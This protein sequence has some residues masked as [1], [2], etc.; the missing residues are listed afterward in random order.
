MNKVISIVII[1]SV[2]CQIAFSQ[3][4]EFKLLPRIGFENDNFGQSVS[5]DG[6]YAIVGAPGAEKVFVF[7]KSGSNWTEQEI[8]TGDS[9][10]SGSTLPSAFGF[11]VSISGTYA[12]VGAP[13]QVVLPILNNIGAAYI[14][15]R[16][17]ENWVLQNKI[18]PPVGRSFG[19][20]GWSV[21]I[22]TT[23]AVVGEANKNSAYIYKRDGENW[24]LQSTFSNDWRF[25]ESV[26]ISGDYISIGTVGGSIF[27]EGQGSAYIFFNDGVKWTQ[28]ANFQASEGSNVDGFGED[29]FISSTNLIAGDVKAENRDSISTGAA[30]IFNRE[31]TLWVEKQKITAGD[32]SLGDLFGAS[33]SL[34]G[35]YAIISAPEDQDKGIKSG[36]AYL[37]RNDG[38][39]W[40]EDQKLLASDGGAND[41]FGFAVSISGNNIIVGANGNDDNGNNSGSAYI[42]SDLVTYIDDVQIS[43]LHSFNLSQNYP[44]PF[45]PTTTIQYS[46]SVAANVKL[47]IY[48]LLGQKVATLVN[49]DHQ[50]GAYSVQ[51]DGKDESGSIV[52]SGIYT[53]RLEARERT[54]TRKL[55]LIR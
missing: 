44:N 55:V 25:G 22:S 12:I 2:Y 38:V 30:Y 48:N 49:R 4:N 36:S 51:W 32:G 18:P 52:A 46:L 14:F 19:L 43:N 41:N 37:F 7:K 40:V 53:Y 35:I 54:E 23:Y 45:N 20:F 29:L 3:V 42:Y 11:S 21:A 39:N 10:P 6:D 31:D 50:P 15:K 47:T 28:Q 5:I 1:F 24:T 26:S 16:N 13:F 27:G 9:N 8:I 33:V 17:G 34:S